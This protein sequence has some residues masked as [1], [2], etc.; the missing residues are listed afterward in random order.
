MGIFRENS[1]IS[2][3]LSSFA[4]CYLFE[5]AARVAKSAVD[6][7]AFAAK[8]P[9][10]QME[11]FRMFKAKSDA[12][13]ARVQKLPEAAP[14]INFEAYKAKLA[15]PSYV[16]EFEQQYSALTIPYPEDKTSLLAEVDALET[17]NNEEIV[18]EIANL[19]NTI[20]GY[21]SLLAKIDSVPGPNVMTYDMYADYFPNDAISAD[22]PSM[23][24][25]TKDIQ[26][27]FAVPDK[28]D[29]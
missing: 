27:A 9:K 15:D 6:W 10:N 1:D 4:D 12:F 29:H 18:A 13:V 25:H 11:P 17:A 2:R 20:A 5:M 28:P 16:E 26:P 19:Q 23:W 8:L 3:Q 21:Q 22:Q 24:P 7:V 14:V